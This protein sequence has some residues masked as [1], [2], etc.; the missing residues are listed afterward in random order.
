[1]PKRSRNEKSLPFFPHT[2]T[3]HPGS[4]VPRTGERAACLRG[5]LLQPVRNLLERSI[6]VGP[7]NFCTAPTRQRKN[8][9][10]QAQGAL[11]RIAAFRGARRRSPGALWPGDN[12][13]SSVRV[14]RRSVGCLVVNGK[15][16]PRIGDT[17]LTNPTL[18]CGPVELPVE[19]GKGWPCPQQTIK[20]Y[21]RR[22]KTRKRRGI[23]EKRRSYNH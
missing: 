22:T 1:M 17:E 10:E 20:R 5:P 12:A 11:L 7:R 3:V 9:A 6:V 2:R 18:A 23:V 13:N 8:C 16:R 19:S 14:H 21:C 15:R 4:P